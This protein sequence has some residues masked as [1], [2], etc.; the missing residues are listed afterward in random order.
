MVSFLLLALA[1]SFLLF[2][3]SQII[4]WHYF[5][6]FKAMY[7]LGIDTFGFRNRDLQ[8]SVRPS[9]ERRRTADKS[10]QYMTCLNIRSDGEILTQ[11]A[12]AF[13]LC[14]CKWFWPHLMN[15]GVQPW[16]CI[17]L[18]FCLKNARYLSGLN[19]KFFSDCSYF[20]NITT[21]IFLFKNV[22]LGFCHIL[23]PVMFFLCMINLQFWDLQRKKKIRKQYKCSNT[24]DTPLVS[25]Q[26]V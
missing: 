21:L 7:S 15:G 13:T 2:R 8:L 24:S 25:K 6:A 9:A 4:K 3:P 26:A 20:Q 12:P 11:I 14:N 17:L 22:L 19:H 10:S 1:L 16:E 5:G 18:R 23:L